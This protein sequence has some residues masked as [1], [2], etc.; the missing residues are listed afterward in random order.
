MHSIQ[1]N[2][3]A[4]KILFVFAVKKKSGE[5]R[6]VTDLRAVNKVIQAMDSTQSGIPLPSLLFKGW[7]L[8]VVYLKDYFF[9]LNLQA[10]DKK[11]GFIVPTYNNS[12][13]AKR[14]Q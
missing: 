1:K 6:M 13:P 3:T 12:Q 11:I 8:I 4:L 2:L 9:T 10:K 5:W 14:Y 7:P